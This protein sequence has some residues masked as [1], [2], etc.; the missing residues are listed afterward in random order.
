MISK[1]QRAKKKIQVPYLAKCPLD[2]V[3]ASHGPT[4]EISLSSHIAT[5]IP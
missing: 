4:L 3:S 1:G 5:A 2:P